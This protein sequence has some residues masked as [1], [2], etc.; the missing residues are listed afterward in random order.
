MQE[1]LYVRQEDARPIEEEPTSHLQWL[2]VITVLVTLASWI[3]LM[4][5]HEEHAYHGDQAMTPEFAQ[6]MSDQMDEFVRTGV[7]TDGDACKPVM[8]WYAAHPFGYALIVGAV[9]L[10]VGRLAIFMRRMEAGRGY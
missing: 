8:P 7:P 1:P 5:V 6:C 3:A 9:V 4:V 2:V 10:V